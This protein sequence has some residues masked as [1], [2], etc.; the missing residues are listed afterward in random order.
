MNTLEVKT[1]CKCAIDTQYLKEVVLE[2]FRGIILNKMLDRVFKNHT[3]CEAALS[4]D[5]KVINRS[6][7]QLIAVHMKPT[8]SNPSLPVVITHNNGI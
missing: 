6:E 3:T 2:R 1:L 4:C 5:E 7:D 8:P